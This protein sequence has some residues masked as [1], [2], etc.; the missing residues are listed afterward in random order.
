M[1]KSLII[2]G[3]DF[4]RNSVNILRWY[5]TENDSYGDSA[6]TLVPNSYGVFVPFS[7]ANCQSKTVNCIKFKA[8][9]AGTITLSKVSSVDAGGIATEVATIV[10]NP[11]DVGKNVIKRF[12]NV[13]IGNTEWIGI[14]KD[15]DTGQIMYDQNGKGGYY[16]KAGTLNI[17]TGSESLALNIGKI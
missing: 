14:C 9:K 3:A 2:K 12:D 1:G 11:E 4:S 17:G 13:T 10:I 15:G 5:T 16:Q 6:N 7:A 8:G